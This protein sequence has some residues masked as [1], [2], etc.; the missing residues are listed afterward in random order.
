MSIL[1][2]NKNCSEYYGFGGQCNCLEFRNYELGVDDS[3]LM[4]ATKCDKTNLKV[5]SGQ[6][7]KQCV[8]F[9]EINREMQRVIC[10]V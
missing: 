6:C 7:V 5:A 8:Y 10:R 4:C 1:P 2:H 9:L 3:P